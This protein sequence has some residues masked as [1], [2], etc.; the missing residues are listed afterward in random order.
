MTLLSE[1]MP[2]LKERMSKLELLSEKYPY[3]K[4]NPRIVVYLAGGIA[5]LNDAEC[6]DWRNYIKD[7]YEKPIG[8][9]RA[10][11]HFLD[12]MVRDYRAYDTSSTG[13]ADQ[14]P[15]GIADEIV[16]MDKFDIA[17]S[18]ALIINHPK[19][20]TGTDMETVIAHTWGKLNIGVM[21]RN[22]HTSP[23]FVY[24]TYKI[25]SSYDDAVEEIVKAFL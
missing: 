19:P 17:R 3:L 2:F 23:W 10:P 6:K 15:P 8:E 4:K 14:F 13:Y 20:S 18:Q 24:H 5:G 22:C 21:P 1:K 12:P 16:E 7:T 9:H 25:V 11:F